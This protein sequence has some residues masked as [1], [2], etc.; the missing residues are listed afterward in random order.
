MSD[1]LERIDQLRPAIQRALD[2]H[3]NGLWTALPGI[4]NKV[5]LK[6]MTCEVQPAIQGVAYQTDG[7]VKHETM[8]MCVDVPIVFMHGGK[9]AHTDPVAEGDECLLVF[10]SRCIDNWWQDGGVQP[11]FERR[12]HDLSDGL[13][14]VGPYSQKK[15]LENVSTTTSQWRTTDGTI[16]QEV[17]NDNQK[18]KIVVKG[19]TVEIDAQNKVINVNGPDHISIN[20]NSAIDV[21]APTITVHG[22][23]D[24][25]GQLRWNTGGTA[26][27]AAT[28]RHGIVGTPVAAQTI[29][30]TP[31][32]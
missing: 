11:Q 5:D 25:T 17:D 1:Y 6:A 15:K 9:Y 29:P 22:N 14:I 12:Q 23:L 3:Q 30:P 19:L 13:A 8:P 28:H 32:T 24:V 21:T 26:T 2:G 4:V 18:I 31:G 20:A 16:Y 10:A 7:S 27:N